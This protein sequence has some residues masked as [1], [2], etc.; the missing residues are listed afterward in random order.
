[1]TPESLKR[2][3][4]KG[5]LGTLLAAGSLTADSAAAQTSE[6]YDVVLPNRFLA[7]SQ[8][9]ENVYAP[10]SLIPF[11][12]GKMAANLAFT[13]D[14]SGPFF[15]SEEKEGIAKNVTE[16]FR[17]IVSQAPAGSRLQ[18]ALADIRSTDVCN[19][20]VDH[21]AVH[22]CDLKVVKDFGYNEWWDWNE[23]TRKKTGSD[24]AF[25][26]MIGKGYAFPPGNVAGSA[27]LNGS[28]TRIASS[29]TGVHTITH[30]LFHLFGALD[31]LARGFCGYRT[32]YFGYRHL[33]GPAA[34]PA[35]T[36][37]NSSVM[38]LG[39]TNLLDKTSFGEV[40]WNVKSGR[41]LPEATDT[42]PAITFESRAGNVRRFRITDPIPV[43]YWYGWDSSINKIT[44][45]W[46]KEAVGNF[47]PAQ[48]TDEGQLDLPGNNRITIKAFNSAGVRT[49]A[50]FDQNGWLVPPSPLYLPFVRR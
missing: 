38:G 2:R 30:E 42:T 36:T 14:K 44:D 28:L 19:I 15:S 24:F 3:I 48:L 49:V 13:Q 47:V 11:A 41:S 34:D 18:I 10:G 26:V 6:F 1:M 39:P 17:V 16:A 45:V 50:E 9:R 20:I 22:D 21:P 27:V 46:V 29:W 33:N 43:P 12:A 23:A 31:Q 40:G 5:I 35:C 8:A 25:T 32:G 4:R 7:S 37:F